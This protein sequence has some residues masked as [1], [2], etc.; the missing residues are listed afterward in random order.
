VKEL[1]LTLRVRN[2]RLKERREALGMNQP[3]FAAAAGVSLTA[4]RELECL[5][6]TPR[7]RIDGPWRKIA[8]QLASFHCV[9]PEDLFPPAVLGVERPVAVRRVDAADIYPLLTAHQERLLEGPDGAHER[10]ELREQV[11]RAL[12][13]L[14]PR[15]AEVLRLRFGLEDGEERT[16]EE[17]GAA[18]DLTRDRIRQL[19][20]RALR[21]LRHPR[22]AA[23]LRAFHS[24]SQEVADE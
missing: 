8:L 13:G 18:F 20:A 16:L 23:P 9:E 5:R 6:L 22:H 1:E 24:G 17:I 19:E 3:E 12:A 4:Y 10:A 14:R 11:D 21:T 7:A 15:D 2:N